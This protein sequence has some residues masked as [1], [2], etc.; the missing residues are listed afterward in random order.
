LAFLGEEKGTRVSRERAVELAATEAGTVAAACP[1]CH[2]MLRD[3]LA[4]VRPLNAPQIV[5][6]AQLAAARLPRTPG[7]RNDDSK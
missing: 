7:A 5:D 3:G 4:A 1:F 2:T 6:I